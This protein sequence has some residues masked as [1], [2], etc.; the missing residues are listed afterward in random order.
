MVESWFNSQ[1]RCFAPRLSYIGML[2]IYDSPLFLFLSNFVCHFLIVFVFH[3]CLSLFFSF[4]LFP[5][6][7]SLYI[8]PLWG[9]YCTVC[10]YIYTYVCILADIFIAFHALLHLHCPISL[11]GQIQ[12]PPDHAAQIYPGPLT[13]HICTST[14][15]TQG[16]SYQLTQTPKAPDLFQL[17]YRGP[18][19]LSVQC[20]YT[21]YCTQCTV[22]QG[23]LII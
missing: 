2:F 17:H 14:D 3:I 9:I 12:G 19:T 13:V 4:Y 7:L 22:H 11:D 8:W 18:C 21:L 20:T 23:P 5:L 1:W 15:Y 6:S 10:I 16:P